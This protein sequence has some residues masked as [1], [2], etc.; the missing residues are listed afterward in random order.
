M[1][2][3]LTI[4]ALM[5]LMGTACTTTKPS[6]EELITLVEQTDF[7]QT[8]KA[9]QT[10]AYFQKLADYSPMVNLSTFGQ[11]AQGRD[12]VAVVL[13]KDGL[14]DPEKIRKKGRAIILV[15]SCIHSGEPDG[16]DATMIFIRDMIVENKDIELLDNVSFLFIP[17]LN[18]DGHED[19]RATN[20]INQNGPAELGTRNTA[21]Q[22]NLN[23]DFLKADAPEMRAWLKLY[24][25][26]MPELFI[27]VHVTN[28]ADFQ[29]VTTYAIEN[30]GTMMEEGLRTWTT[31]VFEKQLNE[32]M[33][34][35]GF[36]MFLYASFRNSNAPE[37]GIFINIYDPR[38]SE[39]YAAARN[40]IGLL[41]EN[42]IYKPYK[43]R[44]MCSIEAIKA[45]ARII[46]QNKAELFDVV[47]RADKTVSS[48]EY[49]RKPMD[50][51]YKAVNRDSVWI[52]YL[53]W[54]RETV[55]SDLSGADWTRHNYDKPITVKAPLITSY[56]ATSSVQLPEA[57]IFMPQWTDVIELF[58]LHNIKYTRLTEPKEIE[59]ET[60]RY[61]GATFSTRQSEGRIPV[62]KT[63]YTTQTE[64]LEYPAGSILIDMNQPSGRIAAWLLEPSAPGS[65]V[66][67][68]FFN[69]VLQPTNEFWIRLGYMEEK[70]RELLAKDSALKAE[71]DERMKDPAF[72]GDSNAILNFFYERVRKAAHQNNEVH[73]A[74][75]VMDRSQ[76]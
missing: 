69:Q 44:V 30:H 63:N 43:Q 67:W 57:Y 71:F 45:S 38:Y 13:D 48:P 15:E 20:R 12:L 31:D 26:W 75:R 19:F 56:D 17:I 76:L 39:A 72:A 50:L 49:R 40:R 9:E 4:C 53:A 22:F 35:V 23:R 27:D 55:K 21:Q 37:Q 64:T 54:E 14:Q 36:P 41:L 65:L 32:Q 60:Y 70:G 68:G 10:M 1:K 24:N 16:K 8:P 33:T 58:D 66:Y 46:S 52:D 73:P 29:Y 62:V 5:L 59:V 34:E 2:R 7:V 28:G 11:S 51:T 3:L 25:E 47:E 74:W 6:P 61:N 18:I 42:H